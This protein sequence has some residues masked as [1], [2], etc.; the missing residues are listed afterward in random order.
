MPLLIVQTDVA[1]DVLTPPLHG[2]RDIS[3]SSPRVAGGVLQ[4]VG[5]KSA[6][7]KPAAYF[8]SRPARGEVPLTSCSTLRAAIAAELAAGLANERR[9]T[10]AGA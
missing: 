5:F 6:S 8:R 7:P 2:A 3:I 4:P 1:R 10:D 9:A